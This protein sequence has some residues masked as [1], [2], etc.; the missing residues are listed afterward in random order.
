MSFEEGDTVVLHD[1][2]SEHD[3]EQGEVVDIVT[4]MFGTEQYSVEFEEGREVGLDESML[5]E[6]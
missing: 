5:E 3:G 6:V 2:H 4:T 1:K